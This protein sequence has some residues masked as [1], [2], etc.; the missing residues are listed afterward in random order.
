MCGW[1]FQSGL[2]EVLYA[3]LEDLL[4]VVAVDVERGAFA[5]SLAVA[6]L[7]EDASVGAGDALDGH[8]GAVHVVLLVHGG[9]ALQVDILGGYLAIGEEAVNPLLRSHEAAL[10]VRDGDD[11]GLAQLG[12][13]QPGAEV[14]ADARV[15]HL[16]LVA[17]NG[18]EGQRGGVGGLRTYLAVGHQAQLDQRLEAVADAQHQAVALVE[19]FHHGVG[20]LRVAEDA[21]DELGAAFGFVAGAEAAGNH[22]DLAATDGL[23]VGIDALADLLAVLVAEDDN[24][25]LGTGAVEGT[26]RVVLAVGAREGRNEDMRLG[27]LVLTEVDVLEAD[28]FKGANGLDGRVCAGGEYPLEGLLP[29]GEGFVDA[30]ALALV[31]EVGV[32]GHAANLAAAEGQVAHLGSGLDDDVAVVDHAQIA[33]GDAVAERHA[34][35]VAECHLAY[36][37]DQRSAADAVGREDLSLLDTATQGGILG[38]GVVVVGHV[39]VFLLHVE[40]HQAV[41]GLL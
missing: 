29:G 26:G 18:V 19:E 12:A 31:L 5:P 33:E 15:G 32:I 37:L 1:F 28:G 41:A 16:A 3:G 22:D 38:Q 20:N 2:L 34:Q 21:G 8:V 9:V 23:D 25:A 11:V 39:E 14:R 4:V 27:G 24:L 36:G 6:H 13:L 10:A 7:A 17:T 30:D 35:L 40:Q